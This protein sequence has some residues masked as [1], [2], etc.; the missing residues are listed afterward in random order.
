LHM[1]AQDALFDDPDL[2]AL[3]RGLRCIR[4][5]PFGESGDTTT[6]RLTVTYQAQA[7]VR[8]SDLTK[9]VH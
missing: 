2:A 6:G 4:T 9:A 5:N 1:Q 3:I 8:I 7:L